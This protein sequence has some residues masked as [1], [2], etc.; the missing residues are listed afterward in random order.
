MFIN[1]RYIHAVVG[2]AAGG[3]VLTLVYG[4]PERVVADK[5]VKEELKQRLAEGWTTERFVYALDYHQNHTP[6]QTL[7]RTHVWASTLQR[8]NKGLHDAGFP[9]FA[10]ISRLRVAYRHQTDKYCKALATAN[11]RGVQAVPRWTQ[12]EGK[13]LIDF[14]QAN[15]RG[16]DQLTELTK[17]VHKSR[18]GITTK[19]QQYLRGELTPLDGT[20]ADTTWG[21]ASGEDD[22]DEAM[23]DAAFPEWSEWNEY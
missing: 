6:Q 17:L 13:I 4:S 23:A 16:Y 22:G 14:V 1:S 10:S 18:C 8:V 5:S 12:G 7:D 19:Y 11:G 2:I 20:N 21:P 15:G 3:R 9:Q